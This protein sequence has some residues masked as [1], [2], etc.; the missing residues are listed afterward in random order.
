MA[1]VDYAETIELYLVARREN[2]GKN[3]NQKNP[4]V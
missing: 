1:K 4:N 2:S 3:N